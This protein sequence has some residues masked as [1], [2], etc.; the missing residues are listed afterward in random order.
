MAVRDG[1]GWGDKTWIRVVGGGGRGRAGSG[2]EAARVR[3]GQGVV[4]LVTLFTAGLGRWLGANR[5][6]WGDWG[7]GFW[8]V[9]GG[10]G[11]GMVK[12]VWLES[13]ALGSAIVS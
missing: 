5:G 10:Y 8:V 7:R 9:V 12:L 11:G 2:S 6:G 4:G 1:K 3:I 13:G